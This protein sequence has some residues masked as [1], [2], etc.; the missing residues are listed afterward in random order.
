MV[1]LVGMVVWGAATEHILIV[2]SCIDLCKGLQI[3]GFKRNYKG[4]KLYQASVVMNYKTI[5]FI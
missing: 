5:L 2:S 1:V 3:R 4:R